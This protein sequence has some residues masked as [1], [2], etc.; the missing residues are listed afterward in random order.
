MRIASILIPAALAAG[1]LA[2]GLALAPRLGSSDL[3]ATDRTAFRTEVRSYLLDHPEVIFEAVDAMKAKEAEASAVA[4]ISLVQQNADA[5]FNDGFSWVGG[6][7]EGDITLVEFMDYRCGYCRK[8]YE[9]VEQLVAS[10]GNIR[11]ILKEFP[12]L[13]EASTAAS[14]LAIATRQEAGDDAYKDLHDAMMAYTGGY[15]EVSSARL[16]EGLGLDPAPILARVSSDEVSQ[17]IAATK[18]LAQKLG[19]TGTPTFVMSDT[20][21]RGY[22]PLAQMEQMVDGIRAQEG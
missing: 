12:I 14:R 17:E 11:L 13:G 15:D 3:T 6:N 1:G 22:L 7:P 20:M 10:D 21:L 2:A 9:E 19:I 4:D 18:A 8:A 5:I 16:L